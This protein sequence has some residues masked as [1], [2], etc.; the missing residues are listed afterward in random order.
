MKVGTIPA[1]PNNV[2]LADSE[3]VARRLTYATSAITAL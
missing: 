2:T 3:A 1:H